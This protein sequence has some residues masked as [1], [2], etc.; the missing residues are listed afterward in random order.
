MRWVTCERPGTERLACRW[1]VRRCVDHEAEFLHAP[2]SKQP[3]TI[4][5][6]FAAPFERK[7]EA[8]QREIAS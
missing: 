5:R 4:R 1:P 2:T 3:V 8:L 7:V 6:G